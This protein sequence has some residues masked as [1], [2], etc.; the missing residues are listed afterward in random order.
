M[1][2]HIYRTKNSSSLVVTVTIGWDYNLQTYFMDVLDQEFNSVYDS[3]FDDTI[4]LGVN[5]GLEYFQQKIVD[6]GITVPSQ[7]I[8]ALTQE[9]ADNINSNKMKCWN[10]EKDLHFF[11]TQH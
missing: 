9:M 8:E 2:R 7:M 5:P 1:S 10:D 11:K 4:D 6:M 3:L